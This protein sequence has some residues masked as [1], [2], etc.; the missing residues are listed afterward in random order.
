V[1]VYLISYEINQKYKQ[2]ISHPLSIPL[3]ASSFVASGCFIS[4]TPVVV[5]LSA[6]PYALALFFLLLALWSSLKS[7]RIAVLGSSF[8]TFFLISAN[9]LFIFSLILFPILSF[10]GVINYR[11]GLLIPLFGVASLSPFINHIEEIFLKAEN[12]SY[13]PSPSIELFF[14]I[15]F[16]GQTG[17]ALILAAIFA[18]LVKS[19]IMTNNSNFPYALCLIVIL[20][21]SSFLLIYHLFDINIFSERYLIWQVLGWALIAG[22]LTL[23]FSIA[24][25]GHYFAIS[26]LALLVFAEGGRTYQIEDWRGVSQRLSQLASAKVLFVSPLVEAKNTFLNSQLDQKEAQYLSVPFV[27]YLLPNIELTLY[28]KDQPLDASL[29]DYHAIVY[30]SGVNLEQAREIITKLEQLKSKY[31]IEKYGTVKIIVN[32]NR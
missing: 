2:N 27:R 3:M 7:G 1:L 20:P 11:R 17:V 28:R 31:V 6:R 26:L 8:A 10:L 30:S 23:K 21:P 12:Y 9:Y 29:R 22:V 15:V 24:G 4:A 16:Q 14:K 19:K 5:S 18:L 32:S 25:K 13:L